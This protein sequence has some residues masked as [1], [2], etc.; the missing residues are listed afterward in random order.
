MEFESRSI[1]MEKRWSIW[2][3]TIS[4]LFGAKFWQKSPDFFKIV[5]NLSQ[6]WLKFGKILKDWPI[7]ITNYAYY[8]GPFINQ[9]ADFTTH[10][11]STSCRV[12][13][14]G[15]TKPPPPSHQ[16]IGS[17]VTAT[18][19]FRSIKIVCNWQLLWYK[20]WNLFLLL[21]WCFHLSGFNINIYWFHLCMYPDH[22]TWSF[23][24]FHCFPSKYLRCFCYGL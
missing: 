15:N 5:L 1:E 10:V 2:S 9:G 12:F 17:N 11:G 16:M 20:I 22:F 6:C 3:Y 19:N 23:L 18:V 8:K 4:S 7:N 24:P 21:L 14:T 13:C